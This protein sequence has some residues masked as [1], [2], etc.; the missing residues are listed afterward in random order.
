M[1][2]IY[3]RLPANFLNTTRFPEIYNNLDYFYI[4][5]AILKIILLNINDKLI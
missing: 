4:T 3:L 5:Y 1:K 2:N